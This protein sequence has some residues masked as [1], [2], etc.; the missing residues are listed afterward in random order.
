MANRTRAAVARI[1]DDWENQFLDVIEDTYQTEP[2]RSQV[3]A[4]VSGFLT[5]ADSRKIHDVA[6][7][8]RYS[9]DFAGDD[10]AVIKAYALHIT[11]WH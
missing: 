3:L 10:T 9:W 7:G 2:S 11:S 8:I 6:E 1:A 4:E 5:Y